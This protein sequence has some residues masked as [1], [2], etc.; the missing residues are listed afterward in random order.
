M[1]EASSD[2]NPRRIIFLDCDGVL[3]SFRCNME[4]YTEENIADLILDPNDDCTPLEKF[5]VEQL[6]N[7]VNTV[8]TP[9]I[10]VNIVLSTTWRL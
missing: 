4:S 7:L 3:A 5:N 1:V 8:A 10:P 9:E 2:N 6:V